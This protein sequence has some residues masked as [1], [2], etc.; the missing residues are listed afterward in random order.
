MISSVFVSYSIGSSFLVVVVFVVVWVTLVVI[1]VVDS[2]GF[3]VAGM[4][5]VTGL[6]VIITSFV[7]VV[8]VSGAFVVVDV[9]VVCVVV[10]FVVV[11]VLFGVVE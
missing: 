10:S 6:G 9:V 8:I 2:T 11:W 7:V 4:L 3:S 5:V 1:F